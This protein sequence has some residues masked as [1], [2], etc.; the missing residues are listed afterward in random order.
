MGA[1]SHEPRQPWAQPPGKLRL[2]ALPPSS[3]PPPASFMTVVWLDAEHPGKTDQAAVVGED[4]DD[5]GA[6][7]DFFVEALKRIRGA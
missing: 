4:A 7:A 2:S 6:P 3:R 1:G 5:L